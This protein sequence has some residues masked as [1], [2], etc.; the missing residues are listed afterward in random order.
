MEAAGNTQKVL[1]SNPF[2]FS[3]LPGNQPGGG[4][5]LLLVNRKAKRITRVLVPL[6]LFTTAA[7]ALNKQ[8]ASDYHARRVH[9]SQC[10]TMS[11]IH[12]TIRCPW[13]RA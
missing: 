6:F 3:F 1:P 2:G 9:L 7:F 12:G 10:L 8:H 13:K 4:G 11:T 5:A